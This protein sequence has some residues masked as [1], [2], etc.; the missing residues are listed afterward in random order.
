MSRLLAEK[1]G[2]QWLDVSKLAIKNGCIDE[3]DEEYQ[4]NVL[5]EDKVIIIGKCFIINSKTQYYIII[6]HVA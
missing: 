5:D 3:Y 6:N 2:L 4:C 1:T